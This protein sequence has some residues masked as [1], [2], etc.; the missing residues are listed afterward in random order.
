[1][2][3]SSRRY[4]RAQV[5]Y[6]GLWYTFA[7]L[8][9]EVG[10]SVQTVSNRATRRVCLRAGRPDAPNPQLLVSESQHLAARFLYGRP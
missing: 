5:N 10:L 3:G 1:V 8:A 7:G 4:G 2:F 9:R 6:N